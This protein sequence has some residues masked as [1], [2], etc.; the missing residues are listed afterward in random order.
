MPTSDPHNLN[1]IVSIALNLAPTRILDVGCGFGKYGVLLR[2]YLDVWHGRFEP[3]DWRVHIEG[4]EAWERYRSPVH[5]YVYNKVHYAT[6]QEVLG[7]L[8]PFDLVLISDVI[9]H[10]EIEEARALVRRSL[11]LARAVVVSTPYEFCGQEELNDNPYQRH[12]CLFRRSDFPE[13]ARVRSFRVLSD[14]IFVA[15][16]EPLPDSVLDLTTP[17]DYLYLRSRKKLGPVGLPVSVVM[18]ALNRALG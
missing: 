6:A 15:S 17:T 3:A 12:R 16:R 10:L 11:D 13:E 5:D 14:E 2:E 9:E 7:G 1:A 18:R 4:I 8:D